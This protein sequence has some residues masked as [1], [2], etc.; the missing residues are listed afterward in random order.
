MDLYVSE[1]VKFM[2]NTEQQLICYSVINE[3]LKDIVKELE[4]SNLNL[5]ID[6]SVSYKG[7]VS[8]VLVKEGINIFSIFLNPT[9]NLM[10]EY[11]NLRMRRRIGYNLHYDDQTEKIKLYI[12]GA[13]LRFCVLYPYQT[14]QSRFL[15][16]GYPISKLNYDGIDMFAEQVEEVKEEINKDL[17]ILFDKHFDQKNISEHYQIFD[18]YIDK[19][20]EDKEFYNSLLKMRH[21]NLRR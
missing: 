4:G 10:F 14:R 8:K 3:L 1:V 6:T 11:N 19:I 2:A 17:D 20:K 12:W 21:L 16:T 15:M 5:R 13:I 9:G 18:K 7:E